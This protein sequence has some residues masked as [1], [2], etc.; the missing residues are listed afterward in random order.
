[1]VDCSDTT[2]GVATEEFISVSYVYRVLLIIILMLVF[3]CTLYIPL[4]NL[5]KISIRYNKK[6]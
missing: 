1:M 6:V 5:N 2:D 3:L 4:N